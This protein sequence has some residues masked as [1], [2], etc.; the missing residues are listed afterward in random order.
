MA[1]IQVS[2]VSIEH[3]VWSGTARQAVFKTVEGDIGILPG[4]EPLLAILADAPIRIDPPEGDPIFFAVHGGFVSLDSD[5]LSILADTAETAEDIDV[6]RARARLAAAKATGS[7][8]EEQLAI[9][10]RAETKIEVAERSAARGL[11]RG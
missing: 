11:H 1:E 9:I 8:D 3:P 2:I 4:H 5:K 7:D 6:E 10:R